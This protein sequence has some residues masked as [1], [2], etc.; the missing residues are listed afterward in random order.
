MAGRTKLYLASMHSALKTNG[1]ELKGA[2]NLYR[3]A[4]RLLASIQNETGS[5]FVAVRETAEQ[6]KSDLAKTYAESHR[7]I[8]GTNGDVESGE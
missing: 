5:E 1:D 6:L 2:P 4:N 8:Y 7:A 3:E